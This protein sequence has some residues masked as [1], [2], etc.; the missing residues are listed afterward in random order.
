MNRARMKIG[1]IRATDDQCDKMARLLVQ[2]LADYSNENLPNSILFCQ[3]R[4][5]LLQSLNNPSR[6]YQ[7]PSKF[8]FAQYCHTTDD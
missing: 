2:Y 3:S 6:N 1:L 7:R 5:K 4:F 8:N